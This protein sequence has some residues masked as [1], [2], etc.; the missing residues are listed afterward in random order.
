MSR[1]VF[2]YVCVCLVMSLYM[3]VYVSRTVDVL[4]GAAVDE[5]D[6]LD[7]RLVDGLD[8]RLDVAVPAHLRR[9]L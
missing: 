1:D 2:V 7:G 6:A 8:G 9:V 3:Y 5:D 4:H